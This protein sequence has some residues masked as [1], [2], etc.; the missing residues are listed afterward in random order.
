VCC[1]LFFSF[2]F[3]DD[4]DISFYLIGDNLTP[5]KKA[6]SIG[7]LYKCQGKRACEI[8]DKEGTYPNNDFSTINKFQ[9]IVCYKNTKNNMECISTTKQISV[10]EVY[11]L[12][13]I[14]NSFL[15]VCNSN[16]NKVDDTNTPCRQEIAN[17]G[18]YIPYYSNQLILCNGPYKCRNDTNIF[19]TYY[20]SAVLSEPLIQ[21][22]DSLNKRTCNY[23]KSNDGFYPTNENGKL[24]KCVDGICSL[25]GISEGYYISGEKDKALI[26]CKKTLDAT[27]KIVCS[28]IS[29]P[30]SGWY[31]NGDPDRYDTGNIL[32]KCNL[33][34][35]TELVSL[36]IESKGLNHGYVVNAGS[37]NTLINC[38][39]G[40]DQKIKDGYYYVNGETKG[41]MFCKNIDIFNERF[42]CNDVMIDNYRSYYKINPYNPYDENNEDD[43]K[44]IVCSK[45]KECSYYIAEQMN[46]GYYMNSDSIGKNK[47]YPLIYNNGNVFVLKFSYSRGWYITADDNAEDNEKIIECKSAYSCKRKK[48]NKNK[49]STSI[50]GEFTTFYEHI[51]WCSNENEIS[52]PDGESQFMLYINYEKNLIPGLDMKEGGKETTIIPLTVFSYGIFQEINEDGYSYSNGNLYFCNDKYYG[53]CEKVSIT[54]GYYFNYK[55]VKN[56]IKCDSDHSCEIIDYSTE[57]NGQFKYNC[58]NSNIIY[59]EN[60]NENENNQYIKICNNKEDSQ[61]IKDINLNLIYSLR[62]NLENQFPGAKNRY[63]L[64]N[65]NKYYIKYKKEISELS[66]QCPSTSSTNE[67]DDIKYCLKNEKLYK[68]TNVFSPDSYSGELQ[69]NAKNVKAKIVYDYDTNDGFFIYRY[70]GNIDDNDYKKSL[71]VKV[72]IDNGSSKYE[73][74]IGQSCIEKRKAEIPVIGYSVTEDGVLREKRMNDKDDVVLEKIYESR[75]LMH[76]TNKFIKCIIGGFCEED[77]SNNEEIEYNKEKGCIKVKVNNQ[78]YESNIM[79]QKYIFKKIN[80][81][82]KKRSNTSESFGNIYKLSDVFY[83]M[84]NETQNI[85]LSVDYELISNEDDSIEVGYNCINE[86]CNEI[87]CGN[88]EEFYLNTVQVG[89]S[90]NAVVKCKNNKF[91]T[92]HCNESTDN[93]YYENAVAESINEAIIL[94]STKSCEIGASN[95]NGRLPRCKLNDNGYIDEYNVCIREDNTSLLNKGQHCVFFDSETNKSKIYVTSNDGKCEQAEETKTNNSIH[96]YDLTLKELEKN[97]I[98]KTHYGVT[99]YYCPNED[100]CYQTY[101]YIVND[102][103]N[104]YIECSSDGCM[105]YESLELKNNCG[106]AGIGNLINDSGV[107]KICI[108]KNKSVIL[109]NSSKKYYHLS[110]DKDKSFPET[111]NGH[112]ILIH[113]EDGVAHVI[114]DDSYLL[115]DNENNLMIKDEINNEDSILYKCYGKDRQC[116]M[117]NSPE[118]GYYFSYLISQSQN[119]FIIKCNDNKCISQNNKLNLS[120]TEG[121]YL[122]WKK[123]DGMNKIS[124]PGNEDYNVIS[125]SDGLSI[126]KFKAN[127]F[128]L[129]NNNGQLASVSETEPLIDLYQCNDLLGNCNRIE[130]IYDGW[131]INGDI[132]YKAIKCINEEC[133]IIKELPSTCNNEGDFIYNDNTYSICVDKLKYDLKEISGNSYYL[134][135]NHSFPNHKNYIVSYSNYVI[136]IGIINDKSNFKALSTC[137]KVSSNSECIDDNNNRI[138]EGEY[139]IKSN[140]IYK[141]ESN[142]CKEQFK[143]GSSAYVFFK[144]NLITLDNIINYKNDLDSL[145]NGIQMYYCK[146]GKCNISTGYYKFGVDTICRCEYTG[147]KLLSSNENSNEYGDITS[148]QSGEIK[149]TYGIGKMTREHYYFIKGINNFPGS[150]DLKSFLVEAGDQ[151]YIIFNGN[152][153]Y[154]IN[155][156]NTMGNNTIDSSNKRN[157]QKKRNE[158]NNN[159]EGVNKQNLSGEIKENKTLD[160]KVRES[161]NS[162][163][164]NIT[165]D[166]R[167]NIN[168]VPLRNINHKIKRN[169]S[170]NLYYCESK[171][172]EM[173]S[174]L[175]GYFINSGSTSLYNELIE[176]SSGNCEVTK[177]IE[178][179]KDSCGND[180]LVKLIKYKDQSNYK[181]CI[182]N[183]NE[184]YVEINSNNPISY[185]LLSLGKGDIFPSFNFNINNENI[186]RETNVNIIIKASGEGIEQFKE[187]GYILIS[188]KKIIES[189]GGNGYLHYCEDAIEY[190]GGPSTIQCHSITEKINGVY[191]N[192]LMFKD[193][194]YIKC[195]EGACVIREATESSSCQSSGSLIY[196]NESHK[197][198]INEHEQIDINSIDHEFKLIMKVE[199]TD[200]FPGVKKNNTNILVN[201]NHEKV[202]YLNLYSYLISHNNNTIIEDSMTKGKLCKCNNGEC[203]S[204]EL[205]KDGFYI[206]SKDKDLSN[207]LIYCKE[208]SCILNEKVNEGFYVS[209]DD[210]KPLIQCVLPGKLINGIFY[211]EKES[212]IV[213]FN[214]DY[215]E[216]WYLNADEN[217]N[218]EQPMILCRMEKGCRVTS[219]EYPGWYINNEIDEIYNYGELSNTTIYPLIKCIS[220]TSCELYKKSLGNKCSKN[221]D[222]IYSD[223]R[224]NI[225]KLCKNRIESI[226]IND[227]NGEDYEIINIDNSNVIPGAS[228]GDTVI[229]ITN[230]D[231]TTLK[232][233][234]NTIEKKYYFKDKVMYSCTTSCKKFITENKIIYEELNKILFMSSHCNDNSCQWNYYNK[235]GYVFIDDKDQLITDVEN[236]SIDKLYRCRKNSSDNLICYNMKNKETGKI[237]S[238]FYFSNEIVD[239]NKNSILYKY[240]S[241]INEWN[242]QNLN[243]LSKCSYYPYK[244][245]TCYINYEDEEYYGHDYI[246]TQNPK[247]DPE[248]V[249]IT[250]QSKLYFTL[251]E[252]NTGVDEINCIHLPIDHSENYYSVNGKVYMADKFSFHIMNENILINSLTNKLMDSNKSNFSGVIAQS[253]NEIDK[254][255]ILCNSG[256]CI[257]ENTKFCIYDFQYEKCKSMNGF[258]K[259]GTICIS[260]STG[261]LYLALE[262]IRNSSTG[263]CTP[264]TKNKSM[265]LT[266]QSSEIEFLDRKYIESNHRLYYI[267][268]KS[269]VHYVN[270]GLYIL[271]QW[272]YKVNILNSKFIE[273]GSNSNYI[274]YVCSQGTCKRKMECENNELNEYIFDSLTNSVYQCDPVNQRLT[275]I[276]KV[277]YYLNY[278]AHDL[279][280]C[281]IDFNYLFKCVNWNSSNGMEGYYINAGN[282]DKIIKC[283]REEEETFSCSEEDLIECHYDN[284]NGKCHS[285]VDLL[286]NSYC[287]SRTNNSDNG[288]VERFLYVENFIRA[289]D[290]GNC[291]VSD[292]NDYYIKYKKSKFL[293][294]GER[295]D[296]I[297]FSSHSI[298]SIYEPIV[299]YYVISTETGKGIEE[300]TKLNKSRMYKCQ[301]QNCK[302]EYPETIGNVYINK[303]S[304]EKLIKYSGKIWNVIHRRCKIRYFLDS[305][306]SQCVLSTNI[307]S[308][309]IIYVSDSVSVEFYTTVIDVQGD[310]NPTISNPTS[311]TSIHIPIKNGYY[312]YIKSIQKMYKF[313]KDGQVFEMINESGYYI[314]N[315][316]RDYNMQGYQS[317]MNRTSDNENYY[318]YY[319]HDNNDDFK[320]EL[321]GYNLFNEEGYYW[322]KADLENKGL[323]LQ[324]MKV[325]KRSES[326]NSSH[327]K[328]QR[329]ENSADNLI[330]KFKFLNHKCFSTKMN[331]CS[332]DQIDQK[333]PMGSSCVVVDGAYKGLYYATKEISYVSKSINCMRYNDTILYEYIKDT[334]EFA[335]EPISKTLIKVDKNS[336]KPFK[337]DI[338]DPDNKNNYDEGY[339]V[340]DD[341]K[342]L[343]NSTTPIPATAYHCTIQSKKDDKNEILLEPPMYECNPVTKSKG[344]YY[345]NSQILYS[346]GSKWYSETKFGY[347]FFNEKHLAATKYVNDNEDIYDTTINSVTPLNDGIYINSM[348]TDKLIVVNSDQTYSIE[349]NIQFCIVKNNGTCQ[350]KSVENQLI[351]GSYCYNEKNKKLYIVEAVEEEEENEVFKCHTG[352]EIDLN[353][354]YDNGN[355]YR[356][357]GLSIQFMKSGYYILNDQWKEFYSNYPEIPYKIIRCE[358][359]DC[360]ILDNELNIDS[361]IVINEAGSYGNKLL[362]FFKEENDVKFL[363]AY[364]QG[365]YFLNSESEVIINE[366]NPIFTKV[367]EID[368]YGDL[369]QLNDT[370]IKTITNDNTIYINYAKIGKFV[371]NGKEFKH[372]LLIYN[373]EKDILIFDNI[374]NLYNNNNIFRYL[375]ENSYLYKIQSKK[376]IP[377]SEGIYA[378]K[379]DRV[380]SETEWT[381]LNID[382]EICY[383]NGEKCDRVGLFDLMNNKYLINKADGD[384]S[385]IE[386]NANINK[387]RV[388]KEDGYYFFFEEN[389]S[390]SRT[391]R[392][393]DKVIQMIDG[394]AIDV[395]YSNKILGYFI[396][397]GLMIEGIGHGWEDARTF[398]DNVDLAWNKK[399][400]QCTSYEKKY[401]INY[402]DFCFDDS[403][404]IC[405]V[406][407][408]I[409][410]NSFQKNN[411]LFSENNTIKYFYNNGY[412]YSFNKQMNQ[413]MNRSGIYV[414]NQLKTPYNSIIEREAKAYICEDSQCKREINL[415]SQYYMNMANI[416]S[417]QPIILRYQNTTK[418]WSK[419][420]KDGYYFFNEKGYPVSENEKAVYYYAVS[421]HGNTIENIKDLK[422]KGIYVSQSNPFQEIVMVNNG[423]WA[424]A[425]LVPNCQYNENTHRAITDI[426]IKEND[427]C[428]NEKQIVVIKGIIENETQNHFIY[429]AEALPN[430]ST[431]LIYSYNSVEKKLFTLKND[432]LSI[433]EVNNGIGVIDNTTEL[434]INS[435][436]STNATAY[437]CVNHICEYLS[438]TLISNKYYIN[439]ISK[440]WPLIQYTNNNQWQVINMEGYFFF[441]KNMEPI[442]E[443]D[444]VFQAIKISRDKNK[445]VNQHDITK[446]KQVGFFLNKIKN[447]LS[448]NNIII[449][450]N[451]NYWSKGEISHLCR[452]IVIENNVICRTF[453]DQTSYNRGDYCYENKSDQ[454]YLITDLVT[455]ESDTVNCIA[456]SNDKNRYVESDIIHGLLNGV[457]VSNKLIEITKE[458]ISLASPGYYILDRNGEIVNEDK[459]NMIMDSNEEIKMY[460][461]THYECIEENNIIKNAIRSVTGKIYEYDQK[462]EQLVKTT[463]EGIYFFK[464]DGSA[465]SSEKDE[466]SD[467]IR[468]SKEDDNKIMIEKIGSSD[469]IDYIYV[470]EADSDTIGI[471]NDKNWIIRIANCQ[472][473][474]TDN[475]CSSYDHELIIGS[476]C[477]FN[478]ELYLLTDE[479]STYGSKS[480]IPSSERRSILIKKK[481]NA[482]I[483]MK[484]KSIEYI[485]KEGYYIFD[486]HNNKILLDTGNEDP[487]IPLVYCKYGGKCEIIQNPSIGYYLNELPLK[488]NTVQ[489]TQ[490]TTKEDMGE[491]RIIN[492]ICSVENNEKVCHS[493]NDKLNGGDSCLVSNSLYFVVNE[494]RCEKV[495]KTIISYQFTDNKL[496]MLNNNAI[497]QLFNGYYFFNNRN[498]VVGEPEDYS[499]VNT[500]CYMCSEEGDCYQLKLNSLNKIKYF[501]DET[502]KFNNTYN[503][504]KYDPEKL[505]Y[506][507][508]TST[509]I[510]KIS[511][512]NIENANSAKEMEHNGFEIVSEEGIFKLDGGYFSECE[513]NNYDEIECHSPYNVGIMKTI[514]NEIIICSKNDNE[515]NNDV[516]D[517]ECKQTIEGGYYIIDNVMYDC[518]PNSDDSQIECKTMK[519]EGF[520]LSYPDNTLYEC[521]GA[522]ESVM[523]EDNKITMETMTTTEMNDFFIT[524]DY[525]TTST[526]KIE[527]E[528][529]DSNESYDKNISC[530]P[531]ECILGNTKY[532][533]VEDN[534]IEMYQCKQIGNSNINKWISINCASGNYVKDNNGYYQ[535]ED[536]K[537]SISEK[538]MEHPSDEKTTT[539][540]SKSHLFTTTTSI[541]SHFSTTSISNKSSLSTISTEMKYSTNEIVETTTNTENTVNPSKTTVTSI[542]TSS[543]SSTIEESIPKEDDNE[544]SSILIPIIIIVIITIAC[545]GCIFIIFFIKRKR[546]NDNN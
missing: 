61:N 392:R 323:I 77:K 417:N 308:G 294:H 277:G 6:D 128:I 48:I 412:L 34:S 316:N 304:A 192:N 148:I 249:C 491:G 411:C 398:V 340:I 532:Y 465:C 478:R 215:K 30:K 14:E 481:D 141:T 207:E 101:G 445:I 145:P 80:S 258:I 370:M 536:E 470:N 493:I 489:Y 187:T 37:D 178:Y 75:Y 343:L 140:V 430:N 371:R 387:W 322:N 86:L 419:T 317:S 224:N 251:S 472:Y 401:T 390:I 341:N 171:N 383:Y 42:I 269:E 272:N 425:V 106:D 265:T 81:T 4:D 157:N 99:M 191:F 95:L 129:L 138:S 437:K 460:K 135:S 450:N 457:D 377:A 103:E 254:Y 397:D 312:Q 313:S 64:V 522:H 334:I 132:K 26:T 12:T 126:R 220:S 208:D 287:Y 197:L 295:E 360:E 40:E 243:E 46:N 510:N 326:E 88:K 176:C 7:I 252:I 346:S 320:A 230:F 28:S 161:I 43:K 511:E 241:E 147:C 344:Y 303:A 386:Y 292:N 446:S 83:K 369:Y 345:A 471:Y 144:N 67:K 288:L 209:G 60:D 331:I 13:K 262:N 499:K 158:L 526:E 38:D 407:S 366:D 374:Y 459:I 120:F 497:I 8:V 394:V 453:N 183:K 496:Y 273:I 298:V 51:K 199:F 456:A 285:E 289:G 485:N 413:R 449:K 475:T 495:E 543:S 404:G 290:Y 528:Q 286:R 233:D 474:S 458:T 84:L 117:I 53:K 29:K 432:T 179:G 68:Y 47:L 131:Y 218:L 206:H 296:F 193:K 441:N 379:N 237:P 488:S 188:N 352:S 213:C 545:S 5:V 291:I 448:N 451:G 236:K 330:T 367:Y 142:Q 542:S 194:R 125:F 447:N 87:E 311:D 284:I 276:D 136:G 505:A 22:I 159:I 531:V 364:H 486:D 517:I 533:K 36:C 152:G 180:N 444:I 65:V 395:T 373:Q 69:I 321:L 256:Q 186:P 274:I 210:M 156:D 45:L 164:K 396:F 350:P 18:Y 314:F 438:E 85:F 118:N 109:K 58:V 329:E 73:C 33:S 52:I 368:E 540:Y 406:K 443:N 245:N 123:T 112:E 525:E 100:N 455:N 169:E 124:F 461:C 507:K 339:F 242:I 452:I 196:N 114:V 408:S 94:C 498:R 361:D 105:Y 332:V 266:S 113:I 501:P 133:I 442:A 15:Y 234:D 358:N 257:K 267:N 97:D 546:D 264:Y 63:A 363:N 487:Q 154:F 74:V 467:I 518:D 115:L 381:E 380:F 301:K 335:G 473:N 483:R 119:N 198:C 204:I 503:L 217:T 228:S 306:E 280:Q 70:C 76:K 391:D 538:Y 523:N 524:E 163:I 534:L 305:N 173:K 378:I 462:S 537:E 516:N 389:Y 189:I 190:E 174:E 57:I 509:T 372:N 402:E 423:T 143:S 71:L 240:D 271:D 259:A 508:N 302:E 513:L 223:K 250:H 153:Y 79:R 160:I 403:L 162:N 362:K 427:I 293:G 338:S 336:I 337:H 121:Q 214:R 327:L 231:I 420:I 130:K 355:L 211:N 463:R 530:Q 185:H 439:E 261:I 232:D 2:S 435:F 410:D 1:N 504:I 477:V 82:L 247:I 464:E 244:N 21:C 424:E 539:S 102:S 72:Y 89:K 149:Y 168:N 400:T 385:I 319:V 93:V 514:D 409:E 260:S 92:I 150:E 134:K 466:I 324:V 41:L 49:C 200:N 202:H 56:V 333:I 275:K 17:N 482:L 23:L 502:S 201:L 39:N 431:N 347:Y 359:Y 506:R 9:N 309:D 182:N 175:T 315:T 416:N 62:V 104:N 170:N 414:I 544:N 116:K 299:G 108:N 354:Y 90:I 282:T 405:V 219:I 50:N 484:P 248:N 421:N 351:N 521:K 96:L 279:I 479:G 137:K 91:E 25:K 270:H 55:N 59:Y 167:M 24:L 166:Y 307:N 32:I 78:E 318:V 297:R 469:L 515:N 181:L 418:E 393:I 205:P 3:T 16:C 520:F 348:V 263:K 328:E 184:E 434:P 429:E 535:C 422:Q 440:E 139:C 177:N 476:Y 246:N 278:P 19:S 238:G 426:I 541:K 512:E 519:K 20:K 165:G 428:L 27:G 146:D 98:R 255:T 325:P 268:S 253:D 122:Y 300:D 281:Y 172:C 357:D 365:Y 436:S 492:N 203:D 342:K 66:N 527:V 227:I 107:I 494:D 239:S 10:E 54:P 235:E 151:Y 222:I 35:A 31:K 375:G 353:Y 212:S 195:I 500:S 356:M 376:L 44:I 110:I 529:R 468:I 155:N 11:C 433:I 127:N 454:L 384:I 221:G 225:F 490:Y 111:T 399:C 480:C 349:M 229:R 388:V 382:E 310:K 226:N 415:D 283:Y 216:G